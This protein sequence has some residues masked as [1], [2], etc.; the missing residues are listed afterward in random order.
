MHG[1]ERHEC[2]QCSYVGKIP[3]SLKLHIR[4]VHEGVRFLCP[5]CGH[6]SRRKW[7]LQDH[8]R[9]VHKKELDQSYM[10]IEPEISTYECNECGKGFATMQNLTVHTEVH[11]KQRIQCDQCD[12]SYTNAG[13]LHTHKKKEHEGIKYDCL[14]CGKQFKQKCKLTKHV[15]RY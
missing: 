13:N 3:R 2:K 10:N 6:E 15:C 11:S 4:S 12:K 14:G 9:R 5:E 7:D 1:N 8:V